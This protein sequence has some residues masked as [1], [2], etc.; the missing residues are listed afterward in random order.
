[1]SSILVVEPEHRYSER[2]HAALGADGWNIRVVNESAQALQSAAAERPDLVLLNADLPG[3]DRVASSLSRSAGGPG[4]VGLLPETAAGTWIGADDHLSKPFT[5]QELRQVVQRNARGAVPSSNVMLTSFDIFGDV[6]AEVEGDSP[7]E[8]APPAPPNIPQ[9]TA[10][11]AAP[12]K[13]A[14][15]FRDDDEIN[16]KLEQTL[17]GVFGPGAL[18]SRPRPATTQAVPIVPVKPAAAPAQ[19]AAPRKAE[20]SAD[21]DAL[22]SKT[23]SSLELGRP[24]A[25]ALRAASPAPAPPAAVPAPV[26]PVR[27]ETAVRKRPPAAG[28]SGEFDLAAFNELAWPTGRPES[29]KAP[30]QGPAAAPPAAVPPVPMPPP[31]TVPEPSAQAFMPEPELVMDPLPELPELEEPE[32][33]AIPDFLEIPE[34]LPAPTGRS[35]AVDA[36]A[37]QRIQIPPLS[38]LEESGDQAG[39]RFGQYTLLEKI[40]A[41]GM[42]EVWKARMRGVEGFQKT[43]AIKKILPHLSDNQDFIEMFVDEAKLAA[44]LNHNNIIHIYDLGKIQSSYYIAMEYIDG[45]DLKTILRRGQ[46]RDNPMTVEV[47]LFVASKIAS[48]LDY[49]HRKK[50]FEEREMGL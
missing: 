21:V 3:A 13:P 6:L 5:D 33:E 9:R 31:P 7:Q 14:V 19:P 27:E 28:A 49:A 36:A 17:S 18:D 41:G 23:L 43:V 38:A 15:Q 26:Q 20:A 2:I 48:A 47:A 8:A 4:V 34:W 30:A 45:F 35:V 37:T 29:P 22:L 46:E 42:A 50:D 39:E 24:K 1:M 40:A 10:P 25:A 12:I 11:A 44:Q 32:I 16:R